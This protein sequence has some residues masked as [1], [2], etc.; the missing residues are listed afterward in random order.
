MS[1]EL[2]LVVRDLTR[3]AIPILAALALI[4]LAADWLNHRLD[5]NLLRSQLYTEM[6]ANYAALLTW[7]AETTTAETAAAD[8]TPT[9]TTAEATAAGDPIAPNHTQLPLDLSWT[10]YD[11]HTTAN[12]ARFLE[13]PESPTV[14]SLYAHLRS[15]KSIESI[16]GRSIGLA[17]PAEVRAMLVAARDAVAAFDTAILTHSLDLRLLQRVAPPTAQTHI[18]GLAG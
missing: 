14:E 17:D 13:L 2:L 11:R 9:P 3:W 18:R 4:K 7:I 12:R 15:A 8:T 1:P 6:A 10:V 16:F 5:R